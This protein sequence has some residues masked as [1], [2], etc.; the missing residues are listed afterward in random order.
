VSYRYFDYWE[1]SAPIT[2]KDGIRAQSRGAK[3]AASWWGQQWLRTLEG[4]GWDSR[5]QRG[6][7]YARRGQVVN[8]QLG[9]GGVTAGVQGTQPKP[10]RVNIRLQPLSDA[11]WKR[12]VEA[13]EERPLFIG[14]LLAGEMPQQIEEAFREAGASLF[15]Q[16]TKDLEMSCS[17]PDWAVPCKHLAAVYY[18][19]AEWL[20]RDPFILFEL[21]GRDREALLAALRERRGT[22]EEADAAPEEPEEP[23]AVADFW[24]A[25]SLE[26]DAGNEA[27][28]PVPQALLRA[29]GDPPGWTE[30]SLA[31]LLH[32][33][34]DSVSRCAEEI[35]I[36]EEP[37]GG[38]PGTAQD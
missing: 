16:Q 31:G 26:L 22:D 8:L 14:Q 20:D 34:Y 4:F 10:Y 3:F 24:T 30:A 38:E 35:L 15:P 19:L 25:G 12:A 36:G 9:P 23:L 11:Q 13:L 29:L 21:R 17:C 18:L 32:P 2:V 33:V 6:R 28:P 7:S 27:P 1:K 5:L 37:E